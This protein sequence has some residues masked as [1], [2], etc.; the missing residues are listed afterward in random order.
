MQVSGFSFV[1]SLPIL[2]NGFTTPPLEQS[3]L[4]GANVAFA[5]IAARLT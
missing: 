3:A 2:A 1:G 5:L 4:I